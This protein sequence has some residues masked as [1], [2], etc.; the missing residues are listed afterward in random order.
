MVSELTQKIDEAASVCRRFEVRDL[1]I[2]G[3]AAEALPETA[4]SILTHD[5]Q[6]ALCAR[7]LGLRVSI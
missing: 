2:F 1:F 7:S 5:K 3:S 4:V 6:L